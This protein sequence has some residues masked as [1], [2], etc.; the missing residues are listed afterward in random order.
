[1]KCL[2]TFSGKQHLYKYM[3]HIL[4]FDANGRYGQ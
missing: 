4:N 2:L 3:F 1:M